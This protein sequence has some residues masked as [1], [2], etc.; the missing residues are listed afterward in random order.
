M[1]D[2]LRSVTKSPLPEESC[3]PDLDKDRILNL[4]TY[5]NSIFKNVYL[6]VRMLIIYTIRLYT[7]RFH[8]S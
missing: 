4:K 8:V 7:L 2:Q 3:F 5:S 1:R 6:V